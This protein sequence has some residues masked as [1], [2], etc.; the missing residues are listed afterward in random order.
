MMSFRTAYGNIKSEDGWRMCDKDAC[1]GGVIPGTDVEIPLRS[2]IPNTI[3]KAFAA[4][5]AQ[6][7]EPLDQS[8]CGGWTLRND[9]GTSNHL[10]GTA[11]DLN[12]RQH[13]FHVPGTFGDRLPILRGLL[14]E[15]RGC[16]WW[17]GDWRDP[18]DEMHFQL[19]YPEGR[20]VNGS[21][22]VEVDQRLLDL[23]ADLENGY[24]GILK[25]ADPK[26]FPLPH[27]YF[28]GPFDG[29]AQC[30]SGEYPGEPQ[31]WRD[32]LGRWQ[33]A[34][35]LPVTKKWNDGKTAQAATTLQMQKRWPPTPGIGYG[36][37][38]EGEWDAVIKEG[39]RLPADWDP[40]RIEL[41]AP[42]ESDDF[43]MPQGFFWGPLDGPKNCISGEFP[44]EPQAYRDGL[45]RWQ[46][47]LGLP[48]TKKWDD[49]KTPAAATRLQQ[50]KHWPPT[51]R[52]GYGCVYQGEWD[53]VIKDKWRLPDGWD[54]V[55]V[56]AEAAPPAPEDFPMP[57]GYF[58]GPM[59]GPENCISGE[60]PGE[61]QEWRDGLGRWQEALGLPVTKKWNDGKTPA[62]ATRLQ[63][64]KHWPPTPGIGYGC[65]YQGEWDA[66]MKDKWRL[67]DGW[68]PRKVQ[69][70]GPASSAAAISVSEVIYEKGDFNRGEAAYREYIAETLNIMGITDEFSRDN[71]TRGILIAA[72][73]ESSYNPDAVNDWDINATGPMMP[74]GARQ[75]CSRGVLQTIPPTFA[76]NHQPGTSTNIYDPIANTAAA[77]NYVMRRYA[78][79]RD[80]SNLAAAVCQFNP[81]CGPQGY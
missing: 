10:A 74:D 60:F 66:V 17:G 19:N 8:Q 3:L 35:G 6:I 25:P 21:F 47:T 79:E 14:N 40:T 34:L 1:D 59:N 46:K 29:P 41:G 65:V 11:M 77:M 44:D 43:P 20:I 51:P 55:N 57:Q 63:Q 42:P 80:G 58:W 48:V 30:I 33:D 22:V 45:G 54:R 32:G 23:A 76:G 28:Y 36:C 16:V 81:H 68:D 5:F 2:G 7:V 56:L 70:G 62:A 72:L 39:W 15:F 24:L 26:A 52:I 71:W 31:P 64:D 78:V 75:M 73:R 49:G 37:V 12:W 50:E 38:H 18:L 67:P 13:P 53:A 27:G 4:R 61:P 69:R 9:V